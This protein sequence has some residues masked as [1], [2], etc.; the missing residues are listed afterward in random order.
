VA[1]EVAEGILLV[2]QR[3][4]EVRKM[5]HLGNL[6]A[7]IAFSPE[8]T[9]DDANMLIRRAEELS[10]RQ[11]LL[12]SI[13]GRKQDFDLGQG[14]HHGMIPFATAAV[15]QDL[16]DLYGRGFVV[17]EGGEMSFGIPS[18]PPSNLIVRGPG[19]VLYNLMELASIDMGD[20]VPLAEILRARQHGD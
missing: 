15:L 14:A 7:N 2:A 19:R 1:D 16:F 6:L 10:Y 13:I 9:R 8:I 20:L 5:T 17:N 11:L 12:L 3:E 18:L 4:H